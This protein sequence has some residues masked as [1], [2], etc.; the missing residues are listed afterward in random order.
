MSDMNEEIWVRLP[1]HE[2]SWNHYEISN[3]G[4]VRTV[5]KKTGEVKMRKLS[6]KNRNRPMI[7][8]SRKT[9]Y[10]RNLMIEAGLITQKTIIKNLN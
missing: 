10:V 2:T 8:I 1:K 9:F 3:M 7:T 4:N 6:I 5:R